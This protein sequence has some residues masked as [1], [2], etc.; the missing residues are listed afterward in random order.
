MSVT[1]C[2]R[3]DDLPSLISKMVA[4]RL[5]MLVK[6]NE[7]QNSDEKKVNVSYIQNYTSGTSRSNKGRS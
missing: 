7:I 2:R 4:F 6:L 1:H 3:P 5:M